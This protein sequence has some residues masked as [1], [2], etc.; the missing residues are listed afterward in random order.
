M[1]KRMSA[2]LTVLGMAAW[3]AA[4]PA[5]ADKKSDTLRIAF[6]DPISMVDIIHD[7]KPETQFMSSMV[8]DTLLHFNSW[9]REFKPLLAKSWKR[10][11]AKTL[12]FSL[13]DDIE[14]HDGSAFDADDVV[15]TINWVADPKVRFRIKSRFLWLARAEKIDKYTV[16]IVTKRPSA[17]GL[18]RL[19]VSTPIFPSDVHGALKSKNTFGKNPV[20]TGPYRALQVDSNKGVVLVRNKAYKH[21]GDWKP[22]ASIGRME[23]RP[24]PDLQTQIA[25]LITGGLDLVHNVSKDQITALTKDPRFGATY[26]PG[27]LIFYVSLDAAGRSGKKELTNPL[28]R[29]AIM[30]AV[31]REAIQKYL[32]PGG[33]RVKIDD[34]LCFRFQRGCDFSTRPPKYDPAAARKLLAEAGYPKGFPIVLTTTLPSEIVEAVAGDLRAVGIR[35]SVDKRTFGAYRKKQRAGKIQI[36]VNQWASGGLADV[37]STLSFFFSKGARNYTGD[38]ELTEIVKRGTVEFDDAKRRAINKEA[39]DR[40]NRMHYIMPIAARPTA[41]L[42]TKEVRIETGALDTFGAFGYRMYWN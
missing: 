21:G 2:V 33:E 28:V 31:N 17:V 14:F 25:E 40:V 27:L 39:F 4:S 29:K 18:M 38:A 9:T 22:A 16:R 20:G 35:A 30:H 32:I 5:H 3:L 15:Y 12:E 34:A 36:L 1:P 41:F 10:I 7:P 23:I 26:S 11:D 24:I 37:D 13:R 19:A 6:H 42:H 8:Y